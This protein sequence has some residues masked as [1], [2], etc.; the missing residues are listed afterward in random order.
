[1]IHAMDLA[2][3]GV[4]DY[5]QLADALEQRVGR[6]DGVVHAAAEFAGLCPIEHFDPGDWARAFQ[7]NVHAPFLITR[8]LLPALRRS[9]SAC[10][11]FITD[12]PG[13]HGRAY[14]GA[15]AAT[16]AAVTNLAQ[17][18]ADEVAEN[19]AIRVH[20]LDPGPLATGLRATAFPG[21]DPARP[22]NPETATDVLLELLA[23]MPGKDRDETLI[24]TAG[25]GTDVA[26]GQ[27]SVT[28]S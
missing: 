24:V 7:V 22:R 14:W 17:V 12:A 18:V 3:C 20:C 26:S 8:A 15:Y 13:R 10:V 5:Q 2:T 11:I 25:P 19:T 9:P 1:M 4:A 16:K 27:D 21:G 6:V 28:D 23:G